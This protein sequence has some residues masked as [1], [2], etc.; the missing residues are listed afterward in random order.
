[1]ANLSAL[2]ISMNRIKG[3][4]IGKMMKHTNKH[5]H[6]A[7][8]LR[9]TGVNCS[10]AKLILTILSFCIGWNVAFLVFGCKNNDKKI[11]FVTFWRSTPLG[12]PGYVPWVTAPGVP[13]TGLG[14]LKGVP[15]N[16]GF[17]LLPN[18]NTNSL[19]I[20]EIKAGKWRSTRCPS[21]A[22]YPS[23]WSIYHF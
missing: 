4:F 22:L 2:C 9:G 11:F 20:I 17:H 19:K 10:D 1:M 21:T 23:G 5:C 6:I 12:M 8:W 15:G 18:M 7:Q 14:G 3:R 16:L 13:S